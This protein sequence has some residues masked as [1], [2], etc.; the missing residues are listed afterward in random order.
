MQVVMATETQS[1]QVQIVIRTLLASQCLVVDLQVL[2]GTT[3]LASPAVSGEHLLSK[4]IV[5]V[6]LEP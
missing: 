1:D 2:H 5:G 4:L 6:R 3:D